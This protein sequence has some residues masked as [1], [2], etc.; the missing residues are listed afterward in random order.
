MPPG[1]DGRLARERCVRLVAR[2][3][4]EEVGAAVAVVV[5]GGDAHAGV[6]VVH[7]VA[8][9]PLSCEAEAEP[10]WIGLGAAGPRHVQVEPV[11]ILVVRDVEI[12]AAVAV[13]VGEHRAETV[14][15][16][17]SRARACA[18]DLA[19]VRVA[20]LVVALVE[21]Q[22]VAD[23]LVVRREA[24]HRARRSAALTSV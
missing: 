22:Q 12:G 2:V 23:A 4:D 17:A 24:G 18:A 3:G 21:E 9:A 5:A 6:R 10:G 8:R 19:E 20:A 1:V 15:V 14:L 11:R 16:R 7:A 13:D